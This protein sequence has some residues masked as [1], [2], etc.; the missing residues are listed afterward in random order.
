MSC[1]KSG[2][3]YVS[4]SSAARLFCGESVTITAGFQEYLGVLR[5]L[6]A[7]LPEPLIN[8]AADG[9]SPRGKKLLIKILDI[10]KLTIE[11]VLI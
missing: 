6:S 2:T 3:Q 8:M 10:I 4:A 11:Q 9:I 5:S 1:S 7:L